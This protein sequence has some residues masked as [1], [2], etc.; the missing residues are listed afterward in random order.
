MKC[1]IGKRAN[2]YFLCLE[3]NTLKVTYGEERHSLVFN[4]RGI[5]TASKPHDY[6]Y[7]KKIYEFETDNIKEYLRDILPKEMPEL[8]I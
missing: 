4:I 3:K 1:F 5:I 8:Y 6:Y 7:S 2:Y